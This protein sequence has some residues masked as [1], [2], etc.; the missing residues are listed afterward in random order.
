MTR[1]TNS[2]PPLEIGYILSAHGLRGEVKARL[3]NPDSNAFDILQ[4]IILVTREGNRK[5]FPIEYAHPIPKKGFIL[6]LDGVDDRTM[7]DTLKGSTILG[8]ISELEDLDEDE[9]F[10]EHIRGFDA[11]DEQHGPLGKVA[12]FMF[13]NIDILLIERTEGGELLVPL[14]EDTIIEMDPEGKTL[15]VQ[16]P[17]GLLEE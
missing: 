8:H 12:G 10:L 13:T 3:H 14:L 1:Q 6:G 7:A 4:E 9:F 15:R 2:H 17:E 5:E 16:L 11:I